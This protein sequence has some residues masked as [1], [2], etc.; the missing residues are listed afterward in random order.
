MFNLFMQIGCHVSIAG[1]I[2]Y[3][4][5][6][7]KELGCEAFQIFTRSPQGGKANPITEQTA[8]D[9]KGEMQK[10]GISQFVV[11]TPYFINLGSTAKNIYYGSISVLRDELERANLLGARYIMT[12]L[13]TYKD[14]GEEK[15]A[16]QALAGLV[17]VLDG[18]KGYT[19]F[20]LEIAAGSGNVIGSTFEQLARFSEPL[21][22]YPGFG[23][24]CFDTQHAFA[25]GYAIN[26][27]VGIKEIF[28]DF[29]RLIGLP[30][31][32][33]SQVNDSKIEL[34][35]KR[36]RHEHIGEGKISEAGFA[37]FLRFW[38]KLES[39]TG[40]EKPLILETEHDKV[41]QDIIKLKAIREQI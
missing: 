15:G 37:N 9:F 4:P 22:A 2:A 39:D 10:C 19:K 23:G 29:E 25:S 5:G 26:D 35:G 38:K 30:S 36:D 40:E 20:L 8:S 27:P 32:R 13:G 31:L 1:G 21:R 28:S 12:H 6:R 17:K 18:Y 41:M 3:A 16:E 7:A 24:I 34:G 11:H 14:V 33:M